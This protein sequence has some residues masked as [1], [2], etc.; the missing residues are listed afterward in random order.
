M[1]TQSRAAAYLVVVRSQLVKTFLNDMVPVQILD[2]D[3]DMKAERN[4]DG[5]NLSIV[6]NISLN[7]P[8]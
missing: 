4:N 3:D 5:M 7:P 2:E 8:P 6:S 1:L